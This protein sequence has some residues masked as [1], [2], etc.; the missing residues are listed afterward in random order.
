MRDLAALETFVVLA[1]EL[2]FGRTADRLNISTAS[3]SQRLTLLE[4]EVGGSLAARTTRRM[5]LTELGES[6]LKEATALLEQLDSAESR[7]RAQAAGSAGRLRLSF[8]GS[9]STLALPSL[10]KIAI[11]QIP[12]L[13]IEVGGQGFTPQIETLLDTRR[14]DVGILRTPVRT[15]GLEWRVLYDD[16][17]AIV[18]PAGH[19]LAKGHRVRLEELRHE[20]H[21]VFP[22]NSGSVVDEQA[23]RMYRD[24]GYMPR[25]RVEV[26][27][28]AT[29]IGLVGSGLGVTVM[30]RSTE[31]L[32][33]RGVRFFEVEGA[34]RTQVVLAWRSGEENPVRERFVDVLAAA[35]Q[36]T[37]SA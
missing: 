36:F 9:V 19:P 4:K 31:L 18:L 13:T 15:S 17:L 20:T 11:K 37:D 30:P 29:V 25:R 34:A 21:V 33:I 35:G 3:V 1:E 5:R 7:L 2:H 22:Q 6:F 8:I 27:E 32:G 10:V 12:D 26:T 16:P 28:T 23:A 14:T 24:A